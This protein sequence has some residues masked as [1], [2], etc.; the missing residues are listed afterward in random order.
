M[1]TRRV[2]NR[3]ITVIF[4]GLCLVMMIHGVVF[5]ASLPPIYPLDAVVKGLRGV[6]RTVVSGTAVEEFDV[7]VIGVVEGEGA[8]DNLILVR[9]SGPLMERTGGIAAGMSGSP[10]YIDGKLL[11]AIS[12][13]FEMADHTVGLVTPAADM[14]TVHDLLADMVFMPGSLTQVIPMDE[15]MQTEPGLQGVA[16][17]ANPTEAAYLKARLPAD[18]AVAYPVATPMLISGLSQRAQRLLQPALK[19]WNVLAVPAGRAPVNPT[20]AAL[21]PGSAFGVQLIR[22]DVQMTAIGTITILTDKTFVGFGHPYMNRGQTDFFATGAYIHDVVQSVQAPFKI[23]APLE[24]IGRLAQDRSAGVAAR[25]G[26]E[27]EYLQVQVEV[28]DHTLGRTKPYQVQVV[29]DETLTIPLIA[30]SLLEAFDRTLDRIGAGTAMVSAQVESRG[31]QKPLMRENLFYSSSD[32]AAAA[33]GEILSLLYALLTNDFREL[34]LNQISLTVDVWN[35]RRTAVIDSIFVH[36]PRVRPGEMIDVDVFLRPYRQ[37]L[38]K[39]SLRLQVPEDVNPGRKSLQVYGGSMESYF[40]SVDAFIEQL[41]DPETVY[42]PFMEEQSWSSFESLLEQLFNADRNDEIVARFR[43]SPRSTVADTEPDEANVQ[44]E[45]EEPGADAV[46]EDESATPEAVLDAESIRPVDSDENDALDADEDDERYDFLLD[47]DEGPVAKVKV[48]TDYYV[49]G[50]AFTSITI[51][52]PAGN[53][54]DEKGTII[55]ESEDEAE[56]APAAN[57]G[58]DR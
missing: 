47:D 31:L 34:K 53:V 50:G 10:V 11:G 21:E 22:G 1:S 17:A 55:A 54:S 16:F 45:P 52:P 41:E 56:A 36:Q 24:T 12:Y 40:L 44:D 46:V 9:A 38:I 25:L 18:I 57:A 28:R 42:D 29:H 51:L 8:V 27:P 32:I 20:I 7:E 37:D 14:L 48:I 4:L 39:R 35:E 58:N 23:G 30:I 13:G 5:T 15:E 19:K 26:Q 43:Y 49:L 3:Y 2:V 33:S 6:G